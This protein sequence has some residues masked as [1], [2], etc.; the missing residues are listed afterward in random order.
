MR[1]KI[2]YSE[3][4]NRMATTELERAVD[5]YVDGLT[6]QQLKEI[7]FNQLLD[8]YDDVNIFNAEKGINNEPEDYKVFDKFL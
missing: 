6:S 2:I 8:E 7:V 3:K 5:N 4:G 1:K